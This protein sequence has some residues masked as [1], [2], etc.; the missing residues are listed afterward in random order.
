MTQE[1]SSGRTEGGAQS[2]QQEDDGYMTDDRSW[3]GSPST[4]AHIPFRD[5]RGTLT[6]ACFPYFAFINLLSAPQ[7]KHL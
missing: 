3:P 7:A 2:A 4:S 1:D 6:P 5:M